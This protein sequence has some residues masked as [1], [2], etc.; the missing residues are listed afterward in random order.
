MSSV[1]FTI[2][3]G[4]RL[5]LSELTL[6][7]Q[8]VGR[9]QEVLDRI[10]QQIQDLI[11]SAWPVDTGRSLRAWQVFVEGL[12]I[13]VRNPVEYVSWV[14]RGT[15]AELIELRLDELWRNATSEIRA[16]AAADEVTR[17]LPQRGAPLGTLIGDVAS[18]ALTRAGLTA[19]GVTTPTVF[20]ELRGAFSISRITQR[21]RAR[22]RGR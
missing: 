9:I 5:G 4:A 13:F 14:N 15:S 22:R 21:K 20:E 8:T 10:S 6:T 1:D 11:F 18:A 16:I 2:D 3:A 12:V 17:G 7:D 19:A